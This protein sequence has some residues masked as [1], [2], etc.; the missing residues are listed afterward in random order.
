M[1]VPKYVHVTI[2]GPSIFVHADS[3]FFIILAPFVNI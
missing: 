2:R 1:Y 3:I